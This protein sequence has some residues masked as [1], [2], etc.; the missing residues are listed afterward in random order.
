MVDSPDGGRGSEV[1]RQYASIIRRSDTNAVC[2]AALPDRYGDRVADRYP[3]ID[4]YDTGMLEVTDGNTL[5]WETAGNPDGA[6]AVYLHGGPGS[7]ASAGVRR[8]FDPDAYRIVLFDQRGCGRSR[9][10]ADTPDVD[11]RTNTTWQM[12]AD[13]EALREHLGIERW[14]VYG[15]SWGV[16]LALV[17]AQEHPERVS[18]M[19][20]AAVTSGTR[21]ETNWI[22]RGV[23]RIFPVEWEAFAEHVPAAERSGDLCAAYARLLA[24]PDPSVR[25]AAARAWC[26]WEDTH[27]SLMPGWTPDDRYD[28]PTFRSVFARMVTHYWS[29][30]CF[31]ADG[32]VL[33]GM[34]RLADIPG[35]LIHGRYD[36]SGPADTALHL[37]R[38]WPKSRLVLL[39]D[40][41]H[42][43]GGFTGETV[44]ALNS[45]RDLR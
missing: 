29:H 22:T 34:P 40:A 17:Y 5:Y 30:G 38:A 37:H 20:L 16:T 14:V 32:H 24:S 3:P 21:T 9:P 31:L 13:I 26:T 43:G 2:D 36:V 10:L 25:D 8:Y 23:S 12:V 42:G 35:V 7:G 15:V 4:P 6:P 44:A 39:G 41:G 11:L 28:D 27:V 19:V 1:I 33:A 45:F 18:A